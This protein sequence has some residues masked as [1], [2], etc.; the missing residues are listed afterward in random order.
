MKIMKNYS[1]AWI[2]VLIPLLFEAQAPIALYDKTRVYREALEL[3]DHEKYV[4][5]KEKFEEYIDLEKNPQHALRINS[6]YY[7]G[8]CALYLLHKDA[9]YQLEKFVLEHPD[10]PWKQRAY[11]ELATFNYQKRSYQKALEWFEFV[12][13]RELSAAEKIEFRY[14]RGHSRFEQGDK[15]NSRQD[16]F[17]A[18]Q[19]ESEY[20]SAATY[21]YSHIAYE[22]N[23]YQTALEGFLYL[24]NDEAFKPLI[25]YYITQIYY[26]QKK[27]DEVLRYGPI[28]LQQAQ[29]NATKRVPEI[30]RLIGDS[31]CIKEKYSEA[32]PFLEQY[33]SATDKADITREDYYQLGYA[34]H[35]TSQWQKAIDNYSQCNDEN[36]ELHQKASYNMGECYLKLEQKEYARNAFEEASEM[37]FNAEIQEDAMFNYAKLAFELSYN[38]FHEAITAFEDYLTK[39][40]NSKRRDEAY[41]FLLNV[42]MKTR[43]YEKALA[44]LDKIQNKDNRVKEA[45][46]VVAYNRGVELFQSTS[47][48]LAE[49][50]FDKV[51]TYP[52]NP[53]LNADAKFWKAEISYRLEDYNKS[54]ERYNAFINEPGAYNSEYYGLAHYSQGYAYFKMANKEDN[55]ETADA[56]YSKANTAFRKY[57]DGTHGKETKKVNDSYMR[58]GDCF[59]VNKNYAQAIIYYDKAAAADQAGKEYAMFQKAMSYGYDGQNDKKAWVLKSLLTESPDSKFE[60]DAKYELAKTYLLDNRLNDA[61]TYYND[62]L[63]NHATSQYAKLAMKDMCLIY[64][65]EGNDAKVKESWTEIKSKY[66]NDP[67]VCDAYAICK[68]V[69]IEDPEFQNDAVTICGAS[70]D[71]VEEEV[72]LRAV[73]YA[74]DGDCN[75]AITKLSDYLMRFQPAYHD[76]DANYF[77]MNCYFDKGNM[78]KALECANFVVSK[79][80]TNYQEESLVIAATISYNKKDYSQ[81]LTHYRDLEQVAVLKNNVLE[82]QIGLMRCNYHLS[83]F[84]DAKM[85][86]TQVI[87][88]PTTPDEIRTTAQL[89]RGRIL[90]QNGEYDAAITDVKEVIKKGGESAAESKYSVAFCL[91]SKAEYKKAETEIFQLI[92]KYSAFEEWKFRGFLLLADTYI[93]L[94]DYFQARATVNAILENVTEQW[95][96]DEANQKKAQLD[97]LENPTPSGTGANDIEIDLKPANN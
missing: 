15:V 59:F 89:W 38:P 20:K 49:K 3:F 42:Y 76:L 45:Y 67:V 32:I 1:L 43:N 2:L 33:H 48:A 52:V 34:Y 62:I 17:E 29:A 64:V 65:K 70:K 36:D 84:A 28:A 41:E 24:E 78:D 12:D 57:V 61:K 26:K 6:E 18:K 94:K 9:E 68:S 90:K 56:F 55:F 60:V 63:K 37:A 25:P 27:Y 11:F 39:Y 22:Q 73:A 8:I 51:F 13:E 83:E 16:F 10:S 50:N 82:A 54:V 75:N 21:Y 74:Q 96:I 47:Y 93:G 87:S 80:S 81:A 66:K 71:D 7:S 4:P 30:A 85:Y 44:S 69:L 19:A 77:L 35:R 86:A 91:Y 5:A 14:K 95:V 53:T 46:Q 31:Y 58:I 88:N 23:D 92:E 72:Y 97:A 79:G 40:P